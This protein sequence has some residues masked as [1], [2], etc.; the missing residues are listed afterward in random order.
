MIT[1][2]K[3]TQLVGNQ[4]TTNATFFGLSTDSKP[5]TGIG[6]G[7]FFLEMNT[8]KGYFFDVESMSWKAV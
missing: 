6:N 3:A 4:I 7:S 1:Q 8:G 5:T 2:D